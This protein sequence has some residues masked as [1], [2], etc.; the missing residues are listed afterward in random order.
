MKKV[1]ALVLKAR[2]IQALK[3]KPS[4][5]RKEGRRLCSEERKHGSS[6]L[7]DDF[8]GD[9]QPER[10][11]DSSR[12]FKVSDRASYKSSNGYLRVGV[13]AQITETGAY[14]DEGHPYKSWIEFKY[15]E[16]C[17]PTST[18]FQAS[19]V[20]PMEQKLLE[21]SKQL[22]LSKSTLTHKLYCD[23]EGGS[24]RDLRASQKSQSTTTSATTTSSQEN[25]NSSRWDFPVPGQAA[26]D[27]GLDLTTQNQPCGL[28]PYAVLQTR[29]PI[30][31]SSKI[32]QGLSAEDYEQFL[33][34]CEWSAI[35]GTIHKSYQL[36]NWERRRRG[37]DFSLLPTPT[38]YAPRFRKCRPAG[39]TPL[40]Q[41]LRQF[42]APS[43][44][45]H[46]AVPGWMMGFPFG[47]VEFVLMDGGAPTLPSLIPD[48]AAIPTSAENATISTPEVSCFEVA[49]IARRRVLYKTPYQSQTGKHNEESEDCGSLLGD[50][51]KSPSK[52]T[53]HS[54]ISPSKK[55]PSTNR[56]RKGEGNGSIHWRTRTWN[57]KVYPQAYYHWKENGRKRSKYI[58][59][60]IL[61]DIQKAEAAKRPVVEIL[62]LLGIMP[63]PSK[64]ELLGD[65]QISPST[66]EEQLELSPSNKSP[67]NESIFGDTQISPSKNEEQP[68]LSPSN[69][70]PSNMRRHKGEGSGSI[71]WKTIT[72]N[73]KD[74]PQAWYHYEFWSEGD[75][76]VKKSKYIPKRLEQRIQKLELD[77][78]P[79]REILNILGVKL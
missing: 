40:E 38:T 72:R 61:G 46:P 42:I 54:N 68:E 70:S 66:G 60:A 6:N 12:G 18:C 63:R 2:A 55:S 23:A 22:N 32:L 15:L 20:F 14:L 39:A 47:W 26:P 44:K 77:K 48:C 19:A 45:L 73:G 7:F 16:P 35:V 21:E 10:R 79:V 31:S 4:C 29:L 51:N 17:L 65:I 62:G 30:S 50:N 67:S 28:K 8:S 59:K 36:P 9:G 41:S 33:E 56:R 34:D 37:K 75:R 58:P 76:L 24:L 27:C 57:G 13:I 64:N 74:Y 78:A 49:A 71:H 1:R 52:D 43:D 25:F 69:K 53:V 5:T 3:Q 11:A